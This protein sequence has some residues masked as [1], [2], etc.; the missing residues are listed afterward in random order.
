MPDGSVL[1]GAAANDPGNAVFGEL[2][3]KGVLNFFAGEDPDFA[4]WRGFAVP[5]VTD[6]VQR[7]MKTM[8]QAEVDALF[9]SNIPGTFPRFNG[10]PYYKPKS[11]ISSG[12]ASESTSTTRRRISSETTPISCATPRSSPAVIS[13]ISDRTEC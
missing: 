2:I 6:D 8:A 11:L 5:W 12:S 1:E 3:Q 9:R 13:P 4:T 10:S 7:R